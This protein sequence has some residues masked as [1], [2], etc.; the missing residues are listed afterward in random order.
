[1]DA[2][3]AAG[4]L[5]EVLGRSVTPKQVTDYFSGQG[6]KPSS[7]N[8]EVLLSHAAAFDGTA[9]TKTSTKAPQRVAAGEPAQSLEAEPLVT[10]VIDQVRHF[11][12][13]ME[14]LEQDAGALIGARARVVGANVAAIANQ[15]LLVAAGDIGTFR[16]DFEQQFA[17]VRAS[18]GVS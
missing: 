17:A 11:G 18:L 13:S 3:A 10:A 7:V 16:L 2:N 6:V 15:Q 8:D 9:I 12:A 14:M 4:K 5:S 1:M